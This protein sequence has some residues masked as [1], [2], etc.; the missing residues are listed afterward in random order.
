MITKTKT[1]PA[2]KFYYNRKTNERV[3]VE[4]IVFVSSKQTGKKFN[5]K[6]FVEKT[7]KENALT[8]IILDDYVSKQYKVFAQSLGF[9]TYLNFPDQ[10]TFNIN[11]KNTQIL[12]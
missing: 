9:Q 10:L 2:I 8:A 1:V 3:R 5:L 12:L 6:K 11:E 7:L 4:P